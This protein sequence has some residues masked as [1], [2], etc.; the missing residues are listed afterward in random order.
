MVKW[1]HIIGIGYCQTTASELRLLLGSY[2]TIE[3]TEHSGVATRYT[4][5]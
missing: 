2:W 3:E 4:Y 5:R 1:F